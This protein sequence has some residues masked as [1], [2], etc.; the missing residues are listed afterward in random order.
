MFRLPSP[1]KCTTQSKKAKLVPRTSWSVNLMFWSTVLVHSQVSRNCT[2]RPFCHI[3]RAFGTARYP[4]I[5]FILPSDSNSGKNR[6][7]LKIQTIK[8]A[9]KR[10]LFVYLVLRHS[11]T[12]FRTP[13]VC[14]K[15]RVITTCLL[16]AA[17]SLCS[18]CIKGL[19][20]C[21]WPVCFIN[22]CR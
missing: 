19:I 7:P 14:G 17:T 10:F 8:C 21:H 6:K 22:I 11:N 18:H 15:E 5:H 3:S 20:G 1:L 16:S 12:L 9:L 2:L 4:T 13:S